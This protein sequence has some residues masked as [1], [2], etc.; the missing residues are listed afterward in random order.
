MFKTWKRVSSDGNDRCWGTYSSGY[1]QSNNDRERSDV[2][3]KR[4]SVE[5]DTAPEYMQD[6]PRAIV[7]EI[8]AKEI[9][10]K[11]HCPPRFFVIDS[12]T[13]LDTAVF[14]KVLQ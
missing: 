13:S 12:D 7:G 5:K 14:G 1:S 2:R 4:S 6:R 8:A 9:P 3:I 10:A 11:A